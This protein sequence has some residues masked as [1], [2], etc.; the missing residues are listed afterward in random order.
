[1]EKEMYVVYLEN[2]QTK[3]SSQ[4]LCRSVWIFQKY[5][6][7]LHQLG[8]R[9]LEEVTLGIE[10]WDEP[11]Q[12]AICAS[13]QNRD[14]QQELPRAVWDGCSSGKWLPNTAS[15]E[16]GYWSNSTHF[17][18][19]KSAGR[20][21]GQTIGE[22]LI[23]QED[24][25]LLTPA[26]QCQSRP[27]CLT[28]LHPSPVCRCLRGKPQWAQLPSR[29]RRLKLRITS[30]RNQHSRILSS[31]WCCHNGILAHLLDCIQCFLI[32]HQFT[33]KIRTH[34]H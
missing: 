3:D 16:G 15:P 23:T 19:W 34:P 20:M 13:S 1:M 5:S 26:L 2:K 7:G 12:D 9:A 32:T 27:P 17:Q 25:W 21:K 11:C 10:V 28:T 18:Q 29:K 22:W 24:N 31:V 14:V 30:Q 8:L 33:L 4:G 6:S